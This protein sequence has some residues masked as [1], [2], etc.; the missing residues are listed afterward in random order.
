VSCQVTHT[1][2]NLQ[3]SEVAVHNNRLYVG[4][5]ESSQQIAVYCA[6][7]FQFQ[8]YLSAYCPSCANQCGIFR[9]SCHQKDHSHRSANNR[10]TLHH[11]V[12]CNVNNCIYVAVQKS[13]H[14]NSIGK[15]ALDQNNTLSHWQVS[16]IPLG[17]SITCSQNV[18]AAMNTSYMNEFSTD[19][20]LIRQI[21]VGTAGISS[22]VHAV[23]L[24]NDQFGVTHHGPKH[25]FSII[26]SDGQLVKSYR[27]DA[28]DMDEP[29][30]TTVDERGRIFVA[31]RNKNRILVMDS[32]T[33]SAY[34]LPLPT[35]CQLNGPY[36]L[37]YDVASRRLYIGEWNAGRIVCCQL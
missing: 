18:L 9:C 17:L 29:R 31:D 11:I 13:Y 36:S 27:G 21:N 26:S 12:A 25:Q 28:G 23:R 7:T 6:S 3:G 19:G 34:P 4:H 22:S 24:S 30:G 16:D 35:H 32:K 2:P 33:L 8:Q 5:R 37:H 14:G 15:V 1:I 20:K 10:I